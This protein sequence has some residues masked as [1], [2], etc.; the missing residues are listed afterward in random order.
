M[1][2][3]WSFILKYREEMMHRWEAELSL[4][5]CDLRLLYTL[6]K[7]IVNKIGVYS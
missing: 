7:L 2:L 3:F 5:F 4:A 6:P 1:V